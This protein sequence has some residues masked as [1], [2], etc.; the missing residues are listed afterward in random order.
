MNPF[1]L[2]NKTILITGASSGIGRQTAISTAEMGGRLILTGRNEKRLKETLEMTSGED[3]RMLAG[4]LEEAEF[5]NK[6]TDFAGKINGLVHCAGI[7][8]PCPV[9]FISKKDVDETF[10]VNYQAVVLLTA[11]LLRKKQLGNGASVVF[12]T[13]VSADAKPFYGGALYAGS[14]NALEAFSRVLAMEHPDRR[15]RANCVSPATVKTPIFDEFF[16]EGVDQESVAAYEKKYLLGFGEPVDIANAVIY[17]LSDA[18][19][20]LTGTTLRLDGGMGIT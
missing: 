15:I 14:K 7:L 2:T 16:G 3:H 12:I 13:S 19:R 11:R 4:D 18:S 1:D 6:L 9:R 5:I 20:W 17:L 10:G 8:R